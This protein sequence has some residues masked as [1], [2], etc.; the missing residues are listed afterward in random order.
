M[1]EELM[2]EVDVGLGEKVGAMLEGGGVKLKDTDRG[3]SSVENSKMCR[4]TK[5]KS[6]Y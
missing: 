1:L 5:S 3:W 6:N 4:E 2:D